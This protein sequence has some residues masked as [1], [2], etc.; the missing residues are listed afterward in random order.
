MD[1][2]RFSEVLHCH[3]RALEMPTRT[4]A[5]PGGIPRRARRLVVGFRRFPERKVLR[6]F[7]GV[8]VLEYAR[9]GSHFPG[10]EARQFAVPL[11]LVDREVDRAVVG[12]IREL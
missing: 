11:E 2:E 4:S 12:E 1:V 3:G 5:T 7:L 10:I 8:V 9:A 6:V